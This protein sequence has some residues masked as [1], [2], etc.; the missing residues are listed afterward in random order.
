MATTF[1]TSA[2][3]S[4]SAPAWI[5]PSTP[6]PEITAVGISA[7]GD[8]YIYGDTPQTPGPIV[9]ALIASLVDITIS[10]HG[11]GSKHGLRDYLE[12]RMATPLPD[13]QIVL[14]LPCKGAVS[15]STGLTSTPWSVRSLLGAL[16]S[17]DAPDMAV[18]LQTKRGT[19][20][21]FF[22]V[23][24]YDADGN[25]LPEVRA[26]AIG[27]SRDDLE[28]AVDAIRRRLGLRPLFPPCP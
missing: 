9:P 3:A 1:E 22:R 14:R 19:S 28:I 11:A 16:L 7:D 5:V 8:L 25:E 2:L 26:E 17:L 15:P 24:P 12:L 27:S 13:T 10:Q 6:E 20:A 4:P 21:T 18:K 23:F